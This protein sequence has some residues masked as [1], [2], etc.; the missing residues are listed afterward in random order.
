VRIYCRSRRN[1]KA[2]MTP[3]LP[4]RR[5]GQHRVSKL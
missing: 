2:Q 1:I 5:I 4:T 3:V